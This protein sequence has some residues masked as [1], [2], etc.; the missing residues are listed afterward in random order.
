[1][2]VNTECRLQLHRGPEKYFTIDFREGFSKLE[3]GW[4]DAAMCFCT[5]NPS[6]SLAQDPEMKFSFSVM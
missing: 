5:S 2:P 1:M 3:G 6:L 4:G